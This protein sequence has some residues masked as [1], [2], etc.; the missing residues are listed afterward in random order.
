MAAVLACKCLIGVQTVVYEDISVVLLVFNL[1]YYGVCAALF[2]CRLGELIAVERCAF[3]REEYASCRAVPAVGRNAGVLL[4]NLVQFF[5]VH[6]H[7]LI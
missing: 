7:Y 4:V 6:N 1:I 3:Q 5:Y 2:K